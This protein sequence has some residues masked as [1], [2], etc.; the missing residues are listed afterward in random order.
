MLIV[1]AQSIDDIIEFILEILRFQIVPVAGP[2]GKEGFSVAIQ[3]AAQVA[4]AAGL[5]LDLTA[6]GI[7]VHPLLRRHGS[8]GEFHYRSRSLLDLLCLFCSA[9]KRCRLRKDQYSG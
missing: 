4:D 2:R 5:P 9:G 1:I 6:L 3:I 8:D 7:A